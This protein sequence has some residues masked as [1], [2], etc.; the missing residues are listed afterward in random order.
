MSGVGPK[1]RGRGEA[2]SEPRRGRPAGQAARSFHG[3]EGALP[4]RAVKR[5]E[6]NKAAAA[7]ANYDMPKFHNCVDD[8]ER[9]EYVEFL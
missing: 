3:S 7:I 5:R 2:P 4:Y 1:L 9:K 6:T 8:W